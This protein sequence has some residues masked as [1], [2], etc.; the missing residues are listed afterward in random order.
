MASRIEAFLEMMSVE[1]GASANTVAAYRADLEAADDFLDGRLAEAGSDDLRRHLAALAG[2]APATQARKLVTL[3]QFFRFLLAEGLREDDPTALIEAP[4]G[5]RPLP[6]VLGMEEVTRLL[7]RAAAEAEA[8]DPASPAGQ[9]AVRMRALIEVLYAS[10]MRVSELV[11]LPVAA[12]RRG[13]RWF[14]IRG[15]GGRERIVP[16]S[17]V[18]L[19]A[20]RDWLAVRDGLPGAQ[21]S[22]WLFPAAS[23]T[24]HLPRQVFARELKALGARAGIGAASLS[25]HVLRHAFASHLLANGADLRSV[26]KLLGHADISTTQ[27]YTHV[28]Q[29]RLFEL[30]QDHHPLAD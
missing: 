25:P 9:A 28:Q 11:S 20:L 30:V 7:D 19:E 12:A 6:K 18:A 17:P 26:Q 21:E 4:R 13:E 8:A 16:L 29:E 5:R 15:K 2:F 3:R 23:E 24:G 22:R 1:R 14:A 27:I 10:G